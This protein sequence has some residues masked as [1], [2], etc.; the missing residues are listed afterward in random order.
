MASEASLLNQLS[1]ILPLSHAFHVYH[2][3]TG[4]TPCESI[5]SSKPGTEPQPT[6]RE[7]HLLAI[8]TPAAKDGQQEIQQEVFVFAIEVFICTTDTLTT[9][10]VSKADTTG[11]LKLL[12]LPRS[13]SSVAQQVSTAYISH[14]IGSRGHDQRIVVSLFARA[15]DQ[16]LFPGSVENGL[17]RVLDDRALIK[18]WSETLD[19]ILREYS[20]DCM[21]CTS[22]CQAKKHMRTANGYVVVPGCEAYETKTFFP[23]SAKHDSPDRPLWH[24]SHPLYQLVSHDQELPPRCVVPRFP[25]DPKARFL[26]QLDEEIP[27]SLDTSGSWRSIKSLEQFWEMMAYRQECSAGR[28][29]G[30]FWVLF[31]CNSPDLASENGLRPAAS[32]AINPT[33]LSPDHSPVPS[34]SDIQTSPKPLESRN[35][36]LEEKTSASSSSE[37]PNHF[38]NE[39]NVYHSQDNKQLSQEQYD[40][41]ISHL[42]ELPFSS[43]SEAV[44]STSDLVAFAK[45]LNQDAMHCRTVIGKKPISA[46]LTNKNDS[47]LEIGVKSL[48]S[49]LIKKRKKDSQDMTASSCTS[50]QEINMISA[51]LV[52]KKAKPS[53]T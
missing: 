28:L 22:P 24:A 3:S 30:F 46:G 52:R 9:I 5:Y 13:S 50:S 12:C 7:N 51:T 4:P 34:K 43:L 11:F 49:N 20:A 37:T 2:A 41:L 18:W 47:P 45:T 36:H 1:E 21:G 23:R 14:L 26:D 38:D 32:S 33:P 6:T 48:N 15:Q 35:I 44:A 31:T 39:N 16:Y 53:P 29:V 27:D 17:K 19:P 10:F 42:L 8:A 40:D 25:D